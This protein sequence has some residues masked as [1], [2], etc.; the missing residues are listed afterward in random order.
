M[1]LVDLKS[2]L[3]E[4]G[5]NNPKNPYQKGDKRGDLENSPTPDIDK[6]KYLEVGENPESELTKLDSKF[7]RENTPK[8]AIVRKETTK[9]RI[10][11]NVESFE[12]LPFDIPISDRYEDDIKKD[13]IE[14]LGDIRRGAKQL[15]NMVKGAKDILK[16]NISRGIKTSGEAAQDAKLEKYRAKAYGRI[17][18]LGD[19]ARKVS[20]VDSRVSSDYKDG[21]IK[22]GLDSR[23]VNKVNI[24]PVG[25]KAKGKDIIPFR[26]KDVISGDY[27]AFSAILTG[28]TDTITPEYTSEHYVGRP[29]SVYI[30]KGA[31]RSI[32][33]T[34]NIYPTTRQE[35]KPLW[36]KINRLTG[37]CYP[38][39]TPAYGGQSMVAPAVELTIGDM[40][41]DTPGHLTSLTHTIPDN[42]TWEIEKD[43]KLPHQ[44]EIAVEFQYVGNYKLS[45]GG[46]HFDIKW[47][48]TEEPDLSQREQDAIKRDKQFL[49]DRENMSRRDAR[50]LRR[51]RRKGDRQARI[52]ARRETNQANWKKTW[53][54]D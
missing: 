47:L 42:S 38:S 53:G 36:D 48:N 6:D 7:D 27:I 12:L 54:R 44:V 46:K 11:Q 40:Y 2:K 17:K 15:K 22:G 5:E 37:M 14:G 21:P 50:G 29:E 33:F 34:F 4:F 41:K 28:I 3:N 8:S 13:S 18:S 52:T 31:E 16:G 26:F 9:T 45:N 35:L 30:Y 32:G 49:V 25:D 43:L 1:A 10:K 20:Y 19:P 51:A 24:A 39:W 23:N